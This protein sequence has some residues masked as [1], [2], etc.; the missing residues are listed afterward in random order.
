MDH[1][2]DARL[3]LVADRHDS[4]R[5]SASRHRVAVPRRDRS[6]STSGLAPRVWAELRRALSRGRVFQAKRPVATGW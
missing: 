4:I 6:R 3:Q 5:R 1:H 2:Y